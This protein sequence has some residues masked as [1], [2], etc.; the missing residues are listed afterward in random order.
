LSIIGRISADQARNWGPDNRRCAAT[1]LIA[2]DTLTGTD[3]CSFHDL[4]KTASSPFSLTIEVF[5]GAQLQTSNQTL[6]STVQ[7]RVA[8]VPLPAAG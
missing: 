3:A 6:D 8:P 5:F 4:I 7:L 2:S 1:S